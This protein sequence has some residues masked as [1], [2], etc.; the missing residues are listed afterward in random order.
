MDAVLQDSRDG[1]E[2]KALI[3]MLENEKTHNESYENK[4]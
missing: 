3:S 2:N 4:F 1:N